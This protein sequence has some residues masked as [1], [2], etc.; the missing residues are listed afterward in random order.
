MNN[1]VFSGFLS[2]Y[3]AIY[4]VNKDFINALRALLMAEIRSS[5]LGPG[6]IKRCRTK[7][8]KGKATQAGD[9]ELEA[10]GLVLCHLGREAR[11]MEIVAKAP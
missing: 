5:E 4:L 9:V 10:C 1:Y 3:M 2:H 7:P 8:M 6:H 11:A